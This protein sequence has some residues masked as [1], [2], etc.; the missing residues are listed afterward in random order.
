[1]L[2]PSQLQRYLEHVKLSEADLKP[3]LATLTAVHRQHLRSIPFANV[4]VA[5]VPDQLMSLDFPKA[6][7]DTSTD[8]IFTKLI[9][10]KW[11]VTDKRRPHIRD[12]QSTVE[13]LALQGTVPACIRT[14][15]EGSHLMQGRIL[16][17]EQ[18]SSIKGACYPRI[19]SLLCR[20]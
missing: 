19:R 8:G 18:Q 15:R 11:Y 5:R 14:S 20:W 1:M 7:P 2:S 17:R 16:L 12:R 4:T 13:A 3:S 6:S 10:R 9:D